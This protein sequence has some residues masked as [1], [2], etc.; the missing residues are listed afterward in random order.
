MWPGADKRLKLSEVNLPVA[1]GSELVFRLFDSVPFP[2]TIG[3]EVVVEHG[4]DFEDSREGTL[5]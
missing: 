5:T 4:L 3:A 2:R 1:T